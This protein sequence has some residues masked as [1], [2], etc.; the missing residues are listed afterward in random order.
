MSSKVST[1][2]KLA[3]NFENFERRFWVST[4]ITFSTLCI[5]VFR[6]GETIADISHHLILGHECYCHFK[7]K[8]TETPR[9]EI[10]Y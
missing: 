9:Y 4:S 6:G 5:W 10:T 8:E 7:F 2:M 1:K 3:G